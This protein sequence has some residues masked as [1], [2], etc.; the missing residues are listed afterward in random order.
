MQSCSEP[1]SFTTSNYIEDYK[2]VVVMKFN[3]KTIID[4]DPKQFIKVKITAKRLLQDVSD[5]VNNGMEY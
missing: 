5:L 3:Q 4:G 1:L 2:Q